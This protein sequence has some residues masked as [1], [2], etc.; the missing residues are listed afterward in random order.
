MRIQHLLHLMNPRDLAET[1]VPNDAN[2]LLWAIWP[3]TVA[4][5]VFLAL[6]IYITLMVSTAMLTEGTKVGIGLHYQDMKLKDMPKMAWISYGAGFCAT[7][8]TTW[9][10]T[11]FGI[12]L[13]RL[14]TD[15]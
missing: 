14:S 3:F 1:T 8:A 11:S 5:A 2:R 9:S 4:S 12:T 15:G 13:L 7:L 6:C 10:K